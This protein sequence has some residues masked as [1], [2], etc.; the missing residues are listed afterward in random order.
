M[1]K[2][3]KNS[4]EFPSAVPQAKSPGVAVERFAIISAKGRNLHH[5]Q[6]HKQACCSWSWWNFASCNMQMSYVWRNTFTPM[7]SDVTA[8][9][10]AE[11]RAT[12]SARARTRA[13]CVRVVVA[14]VQQW[15]H[16]NRHTRV[17]V[18]NHTRKKTTCKRQRVANVELESVRKEGRWEMCGKFNIKKWK[19]RS[20]HKCV[21]NNWSCCRCWK[22]LATTSGFIVSKKPW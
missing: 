8:Q 2:S 16:T 5:K 6:I 3:R 7:N 21:L 10:A 13:G 20:W 17:C 22:L 1:Q 11:F 15:R 9:S 4:S 12:L 19:L 14:F 18:I